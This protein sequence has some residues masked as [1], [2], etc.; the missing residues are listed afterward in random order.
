[1]RHL[2]RT[3][4]VSV[5]WL[6]E[7]FSEPFLD[8]LYIES[9]RQA[10]DIMTKGFTDPIKWEAVRTL[11]YHIYPEQFWKAPESEQDVPVLPSTSVSL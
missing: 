9:A 3:H 10:A 7:V 4:R 5:Q 11:I 6:H 1:M 2:T 8:L